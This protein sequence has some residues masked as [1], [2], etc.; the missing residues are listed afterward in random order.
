VIAGNRAV[1]PG[2][3]TRDGCSVELYL[4]LPYRGEVE[5]LEP[6]IP[7][8][9][10]VLELGCGVGR[11]T[12]ALLAQGYRVTAVDNSVEMLD[13]APE[14]ARKVCSDIEALA[15]PDTFDCVLMGSC[16]VN[17]P[18]EELLLLQL[19]IARRHLRTGGSLVFERHDPRWLAEVAAGPTANIDGIDV[20]V[21]QAGHRGDEV[22]L[23]VSYSDGAAN[24][25]QYFTARILDDGATDRILADA[26]FAPARWIDRRWAVT[27]PVGGEA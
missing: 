20:R 18:D 3:K 2:P 22:D 19:H 17:I 12:R 11:V 16:L 13:H 15:L 4:K 27:E 24:W 26:G 8:G 10:S 9:A 23:C 7:A 25:L 5:I 21:L 1:G 14:Q 6:L